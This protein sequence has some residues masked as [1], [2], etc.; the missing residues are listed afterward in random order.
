MMP[1]S[2]SSPITEQVEHAESEQAII[3]RSQLTLPFPNY[4]FAVDRGGLLTVSLLRISSLCAMLLILRLHLAINSRELIILVHK[5]IAAIA[6]GIH[7]H[8]S[9]FRT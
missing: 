4:A 8:V 2:F 6:E 5:C 7:R 9:S 1:K 3:H